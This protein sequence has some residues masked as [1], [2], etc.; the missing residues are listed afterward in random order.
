MR[1]GSNTNYDFQISARQT[2]PEYQIEGECKDNETKM[3]MQ[4]LRW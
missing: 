4:P 3:E 1:D 2:G